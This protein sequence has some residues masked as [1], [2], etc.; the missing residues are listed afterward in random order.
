[1][2]LI[3]FSS[4]V[5]D[6]QA[7]QL[8]L[9]LKH[10]QRRR[11]QEAL[12]SQ[13]HLISDCRDPL[14]DST[15]P[16]SLVTSRPSSVD[17][18]DS[19]S[20]PMTVLK[21]SRS[22]KASRRNLVVG[23]NYND[24]KK[25]SLIIDND[26]HD[27]FTE[28]ITDNPY[29]Q[30]HGTSSKR[31]SPLPPKPR[32]I[33]RRNRLNI[34]RPS[35]NPEGNSVKPIAISLTFSSPA[36]SQI[37]PPKVSSSALCDRATYSVDTDSGSGATFNAPSSPNPAE[38]PTQVHGSPERRTSA[39][40]STRPSTPLSASTSL[41]PSVLANVRLGHPSRPYYSA[42]RKQGISPPSSRRSSIKGAG[43][44]TRPNSYSLPSPPPSSKSAP[45]SSSQRH[46]S[47]STV[48][49][50]PS[51]I[52]AFSVADESDDNVD[53]EFPTIPLTPL[54]VSGRMSFGTSLASVA[55]SLTRKRSISGPSTLSTF[56]AINSRHSHSASFPQAVLP[57]S[58]TLSPHHHGNMKGVFRM[59]S[60]TTGS[61][62]SGIGFSVSGETELK[63][64]LALSEAQTIKTNTGVNFASASTPAIQE[65]DAA[66]VSTEPSLSLLPTSLSLS[67]ISPPSSL[68]LPN[69]PNPP[70]NR[71]AGRVKKL[72]QGLKDMLLMTTHGSGNNTNSTTTT[73]T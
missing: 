57:L 15:T 13:S 28:I 54:P 22:L 55:K 47:F 58:A 37:L 34:G 6:H 64:A 25:S 5:L 69:L 43:S 1:M 61:G 67:H 30:S 7:L 40:L 65:E 20:S 8:G 17:R 38:E 31:F 52:S 36:T 73:I 59:S 72:T 18:S 23:L 44:P 49:H 2:A 62:A 3:L 56:T 71:I 12:D 51:F 53:E 70:R 21:P 50:S 39:S 27:I 45:G 60:P 46:L 9:A 41:H 42:I 26:D 24:T 68:Q 16:S 19:W 63:M 32:T 14:F 10:S 66:C 35:S 4:F 29:D 33:R 48:P 11:H